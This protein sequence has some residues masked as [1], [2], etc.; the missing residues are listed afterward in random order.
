MADAI[1]NNRYI[2]A[3][4]S[5]NETVLFSGDINAANTTGTLSEPITNFSRIRIKYGLRFNQSPKFYDEFP[6]DKVQFFC[7]KQC[8]QDSGLLTCGGRLDISGTTATLVTWFQAVGTT[9]TANDG[10]YYF[11]V[12]EIVG[13]DRISGGN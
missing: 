11:V 12:Q 10:K 3:D 9:V 5:K 7:S 1:W 8:Y 4:P 2:L 13:I 6:A